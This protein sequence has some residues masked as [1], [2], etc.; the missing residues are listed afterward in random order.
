[1]D[2]HALSCF[3]LR[4]RLCSVRVDAGDV[5]E[6]EAAGRATPA[7]HDFAHDV[8]VVHA[9]ADEPFVRGFLFPALGLPAGRA[10]LLGE[11]ALGHAITEEILRRIRTSRITIVVLSPAYLADRWAVFGADLAGYARTAVDEGRLVLPLLRA[12][13]AV[14][15]DIAMLTGLDFRESQKPDWSAEAARLRDLLGQPPPTVAELP[16]PYPGMRPFTELDETRFFGRDAEL[17]E[18]L[19]RLARGEREI[20]VIGASGSGKSSLVAAGLV[21]RW[22]QH[23]GG[24]VCTVRPGER[25]WTRLAQLLGGA[26]SPAELGKALDGVLARPAP[27]ARLLLVVDQFEELFSV[28]AAAERALFVDA[29]RALR[30]EPRCAVI[31]TL[32]ADFYG[33]FMESPLWRDLDGRISR[34]ELGALGAANLREVIERP[35]RDLGVYL[36]PDLVEHLLGDTGAEPGALPLLQE[37]LHRL[38]DRRRQ[39]LITLHDYLALGDGTRSGL[40]RAVADCADTTLR[41]M[42]AT[43][44]ITALRIV[45]RLV[46]FGEGR[47]D[48]RRQ[49]L[50]QALRSADEPP[51]QFDGVLQRLVGAHLVT[52]SGDDDDATVR[53]DLAHEVLIHAWPTLA[54]WIKQ[55]RADEQQRRRLEDAAA[56]WR[57]SGSGDR[58][59]LEPAECLDAATWRTRANQQLGESADVG[60]LIAAS[61]AA[62]ARA[63][64]H[65]RRQL[66]ISF[67]ALAGFVVVVSGLA[68]V[69]L[70]TARNA[71]AERQH[72]VEQ[73][74]RADDQARR[75][76]AQVRESNRLLRLA[77]QEAG[78]QRVRD[79]DPRPL[80]ALPFLFEARKLSDRGAPSSALAMLFAEAARDGRRATLT[81]TDDVVATAVFSLDGARVLTAS[82]DHTARLWDARSGKPLLPPLVH[83][84]AATSAAFSPDGTRVVTTSADHTA[85]VWDASSGKPVSPP[86]RHQARVA[87]AAFSPDGTRVVTASDDHTARLWDAATG[88]P[89]GPPMLHAEGVGCAVFSADGTHIL[90]AAG[91][92]TVRLWS[93]ATGAP[94]APPLPHVPTAGCAAFSPDGTRVIAMGDDSAQVWNVAAAAAVA[95]PL[96]HARTVVHAAFSPDGTRVVTASNDDT[97]RVWDAASGKPISPWL[98][99]HGPVNTASFSA[100]GGRVVTAS[101]DGTARVWDAVSGAALSP[102]LR[103]GRHV[104]SAAFSPDGSRI[105]TISSDGTVAIWAT[106]SGIPASIALHH[107]GAVTSA[108]FNRDGTRVVTASL[109]GDARV[110]DG[111]S[112]MPVSPPLR[113][114]NGRA[115]FSPD[116]SR[117]VTL[118]VNVRI[119]D[120]SSGVPQTRW[121]QHAVHRVAFSPDGSRLVTAGNDKVVHFWDVASGALLAT[122]VQHHGAV[123]D[124]SF[125]PDGTRIVTASDDH[126]ARVWDAASGKPRTPPLLHDGPVQTA[127]FSPDGTRV[128]TASDDGT[129]QIWDAA[130]GERTTPPL[131]HQDRV[132]SAAFS[133]DGT[134]VVT[135][136]EDHTARVWDAASGEPASPLLEHRAIVRSAAFSPDGARVVTASEDHT[137]CIWDAETGKLLAPPLVHQDAVVAAAFSP[138]GGRVVTAGADQA[139]R[140]WTLPLAAGSLA[141]WDAIVRNASPYQ[142]INGVLALRSDAQL[143]VNQP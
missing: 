108:A 35:A 98:A 1:M 138:D 54:A 140:I 116:G 52:V 79:P 55:W 101:D 32:R 63:G 33:A 13:C 31:F 114:D 72:A 68:V 89:I 130:S 6:A 14:P 58:G 96:V 121:L 21:P 48:T 59:L 27:A 97:A 115:G 141:D 128:V 24:R 77:D 62:R 105:T 41:Q 60:A 73:R 75:A 135:A 83:Q 61:N 87:S 64:R 136:S 39:R 20:Y 100:D 50:R 142:L 11:L 94:L 2:S 9:E 125:S 102:P 18:L 22:T 110:W 133:P 109:H 7:L 95:P 57:A 134:H 139:A 82:A 43:E 69:A 53:V 99:H 143:G 122:S 111:F 56:A 119:W 23:G 19:G 70:H 37:A 47:A 28:A 78:R 118:G 51:A 88:A 4:C 86:L 131:R 107:D 36:E 65:R 123:F 46:A 90:T 124:V 66:Q 45:L 106:A 38:W 120:A 25:P 103:H 42:T 44:E 30:A 74:R 26:A 67:A 10:L 49:Q 16:C 85:R 80:E 112:G 104:R 117:V 81:H 5:D 84:D 34:V 76:D 29:V 93:A 127:A 129:A 40:A 126:T 3:R 113:A 132:T 137:A 71:E 15:D 91:D 12:D 8:F 92:D 17:T